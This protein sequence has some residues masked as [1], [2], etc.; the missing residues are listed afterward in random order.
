MLGWQ[1]GAW[2]YHSDDG[3]VF[4]SGVGMPYGQGFDEGSV[5]GCGVNFKKGTAFYTQDGQVIGKCISF[6][7]RLLPCPWFPTTQLNNKC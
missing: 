6:L 5:V 2:G 3:K 4:E 7:L 1:E